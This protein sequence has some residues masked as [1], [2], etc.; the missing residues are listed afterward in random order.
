MQLSEFYEAALRRDAEARCEQLQVQLAEAEFA[1]AAERHRTFAR[2]GVL[3]LLVSAIPEVKR[4]SPRH[5]EVGSG[6]KLPRPPAQMQEQTPVANDS[7][8]GVWF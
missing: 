8:T 7:H 1:L 5:A 2:H 6:C 4:S 3:E